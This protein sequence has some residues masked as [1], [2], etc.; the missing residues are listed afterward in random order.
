MP[1]HTWHLALMAASA[2][3]AA[4]PAWETGTAV[5]LA[6]IGEPWRRGDDHP[7][8]LRGRVRAPSHLAR[9]QG[10]PCPRMCCMLSGGAERAGLLLE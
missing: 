2:R 3:G 5:N 1:T 8:P 9:F 7:R 10:R 6:E 4:E